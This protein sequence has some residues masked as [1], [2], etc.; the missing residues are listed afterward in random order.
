MKRILII[1]V[2]WLGDCIMMLP[3]LAALKNAY[4][5]CFI[6]VMV[7]EDLRGIFENN[8]FVDE[9]ILFDERTTHRSFGAKLRFVK[10]LR[11]KHLDMVFCVHRSFTRLL[12]CFLAGIRERIGYR[13][14]KTRFL[15]SRSVSLDKHKLH[16][17]DYYLSL[18]EVSGIPVTDH[19][20]HFPV[21]DSDRAAI[22]RFNLPQKESGKFCVAV[23]V[24]AN[25][26]CKEWPQE[27]FVQLIDGLIRDGCSV[28]LIGSRSDAPRVVAVEKKVC[29]K[30]TNLAGKTTIPELAA[31]LAQTDL[32]ISVD[33]GPAH[34]AA[35]VETNVLVLFGPTSAELSAPRGKN[36]F[37]LRHD[38]GCPIPC[39]RVACN[40]NLCMKGI[41]PEQVIA[42]VRK[43]LTY[44]R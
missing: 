14:A 13:R 15:L 42:Q 4:P 17:S 28:F 40:N 22:S 10:Q 12:L 38:A 11:A 39:Y 35:S 8:P 26:S 27:Y 30:I 5:S 37:I 20:P 34:L 32:L 18:F 19:I 29:A 41:L 43:V 33:S 7:K 6:A 21:S 25:W 9:V 23:H 44:E 3:S 31:F 16:K 36:V 2:N 24:T 1:S